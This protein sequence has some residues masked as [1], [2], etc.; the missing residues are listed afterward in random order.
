M[1]RHG[2]EQPALATSR[3]ARAQFDGQAGMSYHRGDL[4][5]AWSNAWY[6]ATRPQQ[7]AV[8]D[9]AARVGHAARTALHLHGSQEVRCA[10][11]NDRED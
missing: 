7:R 2:W 1:Q 10:H 6:E 5:A 9:G 4:L 8:H 3:N 11:L